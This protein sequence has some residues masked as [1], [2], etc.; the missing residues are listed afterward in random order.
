MQVAPACIAH[1][2]SGAAPSARH[3]GGENGCHRVAQKKLRSPYCDLPIAI[4]PFGLD[5]LFEQVRLLSG[6]RT[7]SLPKLGRQ[8]LSKSRRRAVWRAQRLHPICISTHMDIPFSFLRGGMWEKEG[9][10]PIWPSP[11]SFKIPGSLP[12]ET[13]APFG[14]AMICSK[15]PGMGKRSMK[16]GELPNGHMGISTRAM[17]G[18]RGDRMDR[19]KRSR[20][21]LALLLLQGDLHSPSH[22]RSGSSDCADYE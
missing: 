8:D 13:A 19:R 14:P 21:N 10:G 3:N 7:D 16:M 1:P 22:L 4:F 2:D 12:A 6:R 5:R 20:A 9:R 15:L 18:G 11:A 17:C